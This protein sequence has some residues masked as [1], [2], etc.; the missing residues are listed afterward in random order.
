[1]QSLLLEGRAAQSPRGA[2]HLDSVLRHTWCWFLALGCLQLLLHWKRKLV[3]YVSQQC[4]NSSQPEMEQVQKTLSSPFVSSV[5]SLLALSGDVFPYRYPKTVSGRGT[6]QVQCRR[7]VAPPVP[8]HGLCHEL[9]CHCCAAPEQPQPRSTDTSLTCQEHRGRGGAKNTL[10]NLDISVLS[11]WACKFTS[12][13]L[14][15][16]PDS[17]TQLQSRLP[18]VQHF[19]LQPHCL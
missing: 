5:G 18:D 6:E 4:V 17:S 2:P 9:C 13:W 1:M 10:I 11:M 15:F 12:I 8:H 16:T 3:H 19:P 14:C 7:S